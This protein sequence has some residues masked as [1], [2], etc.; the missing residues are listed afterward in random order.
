VTVDDIDVATKDS[1]TGV[2][3]ANSHNIE[4]SLS[5]TYNEEMNFKITAPKN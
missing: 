3:K 5:G 2:W 4:Y 1:S